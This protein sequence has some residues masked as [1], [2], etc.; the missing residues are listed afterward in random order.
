MNFISATIVIVTW[1]TTLRSMRQRYVCVSLRKKNKA[2]VAN[3]GTEMR[4][5]LTNATQTVRVGRF[6]SVL[7]YLCPQWTQTG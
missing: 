5:Y 1:I 3:A 6:N 2:H 7:A 4:V